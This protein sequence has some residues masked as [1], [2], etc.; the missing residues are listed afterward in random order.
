MIIL[1]V[2]DKETKVSIDTLG[3]EPGLA[4]ATTNYDDA[5]LITGKDVFKKKEFV[6][7]K[8][9]WWQKNGT[10]KIPRLKRSLE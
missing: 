3:C 5:H 6:V 8:S 4:V 10:L 2:K 7:Y 9:P 1:G